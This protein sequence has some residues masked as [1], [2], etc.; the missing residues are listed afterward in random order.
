M[1]YHTDHGA[2]KAMKKVKENSVEK[3]MAKPKRKKP[4]KIFEKMP[5]N[6]H[7]MAD[8]I[9]MSGKTHSKDSKVLGKL[10]PMKKAKKGSKEMKEKMA[11]LRAMRKKK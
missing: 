10:K 4:M 8:G 6:A 2:K 5:M 1:P 3:R 7:K 11:K 9:I